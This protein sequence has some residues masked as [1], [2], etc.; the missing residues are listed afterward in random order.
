MKP[1]VTIYLGQVIRELRVESGLS[2]VVFAER[3]GLFQTYLS[4]VENGLANPTVNALD[5]I[6]ATLGLTIFDLFALAS[7]RAQIQSSPT[8]KRLPRH[9]PAK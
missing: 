5:V 4:R 8:A 6:A 1:T 9:K 7:C 3:A 2:Q